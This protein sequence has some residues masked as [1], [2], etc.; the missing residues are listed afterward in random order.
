[1]PSAA[2]VA[3][4][5]A[6]KVESSYGQAPTQASAQLLRRATSSFNFAKE[7]YQSQEI[8]TDYQRVDFRH[9]VGAVN[10]TLEGELSPGTYKDFIA[11]ALKKD[12][13]AVTAAT[14]VS[15]TIA[16]SGSY[17]TITRGAGSYLTDGFKTGMVIRL[18]VGSLNAANINKNLL[19]LE[20]TSATVIKVTP[21]N[22]SSM[23]AE[24][25]IASTTITATG[26]VTYIPTSSHTNKSFAFEEWYSDVSLSELFLGCRIAKLGFKL[27]ASG[28]AG[29]SLGI[30]GQDVANTTAKR[31][32]VALSSQ[33]FTT[34]TALTTAGVLAAANGKIAAGGAL[35]ANVTGLSIDVENAFTSEAL[36]GSNIRSE[37]TSGRV[38]VK[39]QMTA[40]FDSSTFR[41]AFWNETL[42]DVI[43]A[44]SVDNTATSEFLVV[45]LPAIKFGDAA[46]DD[47]E[48]T[49]VQTL[50]F[51]AI[52][53]TTGS[54]TSTDTY[55]TTI[56]VQDSLA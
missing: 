53:D 9:G 23:A 44:L 2:G 37:L 20:I 38:L 4:Q 10:G 46:K 47:G 19:I 7:A 21:L 41:D 11:A 12:F 33:Y 16:T 31:G 51:E 14:G 45:S 6:Y 49:V 30:M 13:A 55:Q 32:A 15:V 40:I 3:K 50:P 24:G 36:V 29:I 26:K 1:M 34:P 17:Y 43:L 25:P 39:G 56:M 8:R 28:M 52:M 42:Q 22:G 27:P 35:L 48:K 5:L 18:S 54:A